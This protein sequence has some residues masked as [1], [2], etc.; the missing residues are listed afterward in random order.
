MRILLLGDPHLKISRFNES[1]EL[2]KWFNTLV[3]EIKPDLVVNLGDTMDTHGVLRSELMY[4][5]KRHVEECVAVCPYIYVIGNHDLHRV[6]SYRYHALQSFSIPGM[7]VVDEITDLYN[8]TFVPYTHDLTQFPMN[9]KSIC[10][11]HQTFVG[12]DYGYYRPDVGVD[13]D[14]CNAEII[15]SGHVHKRQNFGKVYYPGTPSAHDLNDIDQI[16]GVDLFDTETYEFSFFPSP[17]PNYKSLTYNL[18]SGSSIE[19][20]HNDLLQTL[21]DKDYWIVKLKG[22][23]PEIIAYMK[24]K[25]WLKLQKKYN[26]RIK[27]EFVS[28]EKVER[29]KIKSA[30][31]Y[32][33]VDE[34]IDKVY[35]GALDKDVLKLLSNRFINTSIK[36]TV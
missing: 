20:I 26:T 31:I 5:F 23:K 32:N 9:T 28:G 30:D 8:I 15:I 33:I 1:V 24:S 21:N 16:K 19:E 34:Y 12:C 35:D 29:V 4:E 3:L 6:N 17:F 14:K 11:A 18:S 36:S 27:P 7:K 25:D 13:A 2:L 22:P 10:I